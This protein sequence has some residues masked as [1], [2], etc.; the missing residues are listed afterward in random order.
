MINRNFGV[1]DKID[2]SFAIRRGKT[3]INPRTFLHCVFHT[4]L[5]GLKNMPVCILDHNLK[6]LQTSATSKEE[7]FNNLF[8]LSSIMLPRT[9]LCY[10]PNKIGVQKKSGSFLYLSSSTYCASK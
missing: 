10:K 6:V 5:P 3:Q 2:P 8:N 4:V 7:Y 9:I 1:H